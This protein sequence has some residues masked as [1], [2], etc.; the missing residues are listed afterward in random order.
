MVGDTENYRT[1]LSSRYEGAL[2]R[3]RELETS[4]TN[5]SSTPKN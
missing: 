2:T 4:P 1:E 5:R 3:M